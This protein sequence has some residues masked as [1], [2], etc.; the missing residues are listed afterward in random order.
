MYDQNPYSLDIFQD[1][2]FLKGNQN[3]LKYLHN[4]DF[5]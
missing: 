5:E 1:I 2:W 4:F 3:F